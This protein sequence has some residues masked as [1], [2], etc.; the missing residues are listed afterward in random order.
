MFARANLAAE[1]HSYSRFFL[2]LTTLIFL[3][4]V[5]STAHAQKG[6]KPPKDDPPPALPNV[7]YRLE[8]MLIDAQIT[9]VREMNGQGLIVGSL[10][11]PSD[12]Q[13]YVYDHDGLFN[14]GVSPAVDAGYDPVYNLH[15]LFADQLPA[16]FQLDWVGGINQWGDI[17]GSVKDETG[18]W[19]GFVIDTSATAFTDPTAPISPNTADWTLRFLPTVNSSSSWGVSINE[20]GV[21]AGYYEDSTTGVG[22]AYLY[23]AFVSNADPVPLGVELDD[24]DV[25]LNNQNQVV[26][27][28]TNQDA[29]FYDPE[30]GVRIISAEGRGDW[31]FDINGLNDSGTFSGSVS[32]QINGKGSRRG[33]AF[34]YA[35]QLELLVTDE[36]VHAGFIN[37]SNDVLAATFISSDA[38]YLIHS[39]FTPGDG[40]QTLL[41]DDLIDENDPLKSIWTDPELGNSLDG[42][43]DRDPVIGYPSL[44]GTFVNSDGRHIGV[45][46]TPFSTSQSLAATAVPEPATAWNVVAGLWSVLVLIG[47]RR[48]APSLKSF[49][50]ARGFPVASPSTVGRSVLL[51]DAKRKVDRRQVP[52]RV[53]TRTRGGWRVSAT[54]VLVVS[55]FAPGEV[56]LAEV[57]TVLLLSSGNSLQDA[58]LTRILEEGGHRVSLGPQYTD[59]TS[60]LDL[61]DIAAVFLQA[62]YN[63]SPDPASRGGETEDM[64]TSGQIRLLEYLQAGGGLVTTEWLVWKH[65]ANAQDNRNWEPNFLTLY[66]AIPVISTN[67]YRGD[68]VVVYTEAISDDVIT[69][70]VPDSFSFAGQSIAGVETYF[71]PKSGATVYYSSDYGDGL[72]G[73][74]FGSGRVLSFSTVVGLSSLANRDYA[75]LV[76]NATTWVTG[77][78]LHQ[79]MGDFNYDGTVDGK[80]FLLWQRGESPEPHSP[81]DLA[82]WQ[83]NYGAASSLASANLV[84]E[85][86]TWL[87]IGCG[88]ASLLV[89][90]NRH[91]RIACQCFEQ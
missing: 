1:N 27:I 29:F 62:N 84:P 90:C 89:V 23:N 64:P 49:T 79:L 26:G 36:T 12:S 10:Q 45:V 82:A 68:P 70:G 15:E 66:D 34:R 11:G 14:G 63:W 6:K 48:Y 51:D 87:Q 8:P 77:E 72:I 24:W 17:V 73:W 2:V 40:E 91:G 32:T 61:S 47:R 85:P 71:A 52:T 81:A 5:V 38:H 80:D 53:L 55:F 22:D 86:S 41:V 19:R 35:D 28:V 4:S 78:K 83:A 31:F 7:R 58:T 54:G 18:N 67:A 25:Q 39:N 69:A 88:L 30:S 76:S 37:E 50:L 75:R 3:I 60:S 9:R 44:L 57:K 65:G 74:G 43:E 21:V 33:V 13:G 59:F 46:L 42:L 56:A 20:N 16:N